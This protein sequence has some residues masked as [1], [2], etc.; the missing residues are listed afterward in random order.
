MNRPPAS[1]SLDC[2][3][4]LQQTLQRRVAS[5]DAENVRSVGFSPL[6]SGDSG[7]AV[8]QA[9][10]DVNRKR[11][12]VPPGKRIEPVEPVR[13]L[14]RSTSTYR[15]LEL[16]TQIRQTGSILPTG[17]SISTE[18]GRATTSMVVRWTTVRPTPSRPDARQ[19]DDPRW[20]WGLVTVSHLFVGRGDLDSQSRAAVRRVAACGDGPDA[21][22]SRVAARGRIPGG[23]DVAIVETGWDR[24]W[25]SGFLP[26]IGL[27]PLAV[28][29][30][31]DLARWASTGTSGDF[32]GDAIAVPW[33]WDAFYPTLAIPTLGRLQHIIAY[34]SV[35]S[36][37]RR[38]S[39]FGPGSSGGVLVAGGLVLGV[40]VA[41]MRP[42]FRV[43]YAQS[44]DISLQWLR[45]KLHATALDCVNVV[46]KNS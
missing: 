8:V 18:E 36:D 7:D 23:P 46:T 9:R 12:R 38:R 5:R 27:P 15:E 16:P 45:K 43:G 35:P 6:Q 2:L 40:Q 19:P 30:G 10:F 26:E 41:A 31:E 33:Y 11:K 22:R 29:T 14:D 42:E 24:L 20:R 25:L 21:I 4:R 39:P 1:L 34:E 32:V 17:V 28:V 3:R 37:E 44:F 13:L